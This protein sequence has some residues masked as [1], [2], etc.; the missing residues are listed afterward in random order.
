MSK[1]LIDL[2][3][4]G[5]NFK[6]KRLVQNLIGQMNYINLGTGRCKIWTNTVEPSTVKG[7]S[8]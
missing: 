4:G 6:N 5:K 2:V 7:Y 3:M 1:N 8:Y